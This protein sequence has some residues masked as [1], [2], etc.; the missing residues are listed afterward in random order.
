MLLASAVNTNA[1]RQKASLSR[2]RGDIL[3]VSAVNTNASRRIVIRTDFFSLPITLHFYIVQ[4]HHQIISCCVDCNR[5][6]NL[7]VTFAPLTMFRWQVFV[8]Q[9]MRSPWST[10]LDGGAKDGDRDSLK[11]H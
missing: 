7:T 11:V 6:L 5:F 10:F 1:S 4:L 9:G 3:L 8:A 2:C